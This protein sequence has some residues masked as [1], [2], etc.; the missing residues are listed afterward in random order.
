MLSIKV[1]C[2]QQLARRR[3]RESTLCNNGGL[4]IAGG[5]VD[6]STP[7]FLMGWPGHLSH[8]TSTYKFVGAGSYISGELPVFHQ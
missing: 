4:E 3:D 5:M 2:D 8:H 7:S 1:G 6:Y